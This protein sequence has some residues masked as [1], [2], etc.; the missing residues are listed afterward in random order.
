MIL[1]SLEGLGVGA[2]QAA[3]VLSVAPEGT[4][5]AAR[6]TARILQ[7]LVA[8]AQFRELSGCRLWSRVG[9]S[10]SFWEV[11]QTPA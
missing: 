6:L 4:F 9:R 5:L 2:A 1:S 10:D 3:L 11:R 8:A 7:V